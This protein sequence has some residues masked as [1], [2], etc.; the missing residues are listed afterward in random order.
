MAKVNIEEYKKSVRKK[1]KLP[2]GL[3]LTVRRMSLRT[4]IQLYDVWPVKE[5]D[6]RDPT[7]IKLLPQILEIVLPACVEEIPEQLEIDDLAPGDAMELLT[8]IFEFSGLTAEEMK[9]RRKFR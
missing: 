6:P 3:E 9:R 7:F 5:P 8:A 4:F 1:V 2:S